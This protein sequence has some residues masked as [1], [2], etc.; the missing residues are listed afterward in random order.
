M[1][2]LAI[3]SPIWLKP[4]SPAAQ[5]FPAKSPEAPIVTFLGCTAEVPSPSEHVQ[6][7]LAD[8]PGRFS[9]ALPLFL[10]EQ[11]EFN[12]RARTQ[13]LVPWVAQNGG[14]FILGGSPWSDVDAVKYCRQAQVVGKYVVVSHLKSQTGPWIAELRVIRLD[15]S[16]RLGHLKVS[17]RSDDSGNSVAELSRSLVSLLIREAGS[18]PQRS[19][20]YQ[21]P[22]GANLPNYLLRLEQLLAVRCAG[23]NA[24]GS[25]LNGEREI[26][27]GN[28]QLCLPC[29][30]N[31][32]T[33]IL[34][35]H[36]LLA[37][38]RVRPD[39]VAEFKGKVTLLQNEKP[40][41]HSA[42]DVIQR[43]LDEAMS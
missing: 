18:V 25:F 12:T 15:D 32:G 43:L 40:L 5:L 42:H 23:M 24:S 20:L 31:I 19:A 1:T 10:A 16:E 17:F 2:F 3:E 7:Q 13:T 41:T 30:E 8:A 9:R 37:M 34:L 22:E 6:R 29:P 33:R 21:A 14:G 36:T 35:A 38:K 28:V 4:S 27:D 26:L 11:L 39:V